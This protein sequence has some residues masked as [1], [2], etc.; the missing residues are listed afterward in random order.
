MAQVKSQNLRLAIKYA[1][2]ADVAIPN[3]PYVKCLT[4]Y[5]CA[6]A[7]EPKYLK[8]VFIFSFEFRM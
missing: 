2:E 4:A 3:H 7:K 8:N 1:K 6:N 5:T